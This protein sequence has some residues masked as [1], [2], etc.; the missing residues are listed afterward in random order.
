[1][2]LAPRLSGAPVGAALLGM[3]INMTITI[4]TNITIISIVS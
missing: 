4:I 3:V 1:M 2:P